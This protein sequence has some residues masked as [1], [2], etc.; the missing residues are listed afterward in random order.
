[1]LWIMLIQAVASDSI[2]SAVRYKIVRGLVNQ[3]YVLE[4]MQW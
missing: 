2:L 1:M 4:S 3:V